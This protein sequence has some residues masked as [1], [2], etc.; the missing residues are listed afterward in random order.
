DLD[1]RILHGEKL[2]FRVLDFVLID[3]SVT[4]IRISPV[5]LYYKA[6]VGSVVRNA[7]TAG[8][9]DGEAVTSSFMAPAIFYVRA[10]TMILHALAFIWLTVKS[11]CDHRDRPAWDDLFDKT[12]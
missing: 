9:F 4:T 5:M 3:A 2:P 1:Q 7:Q 11:A 8:S 6:S 12:N 10:R